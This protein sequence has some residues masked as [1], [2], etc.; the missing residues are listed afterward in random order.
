MFA[1]LLGGFLLPEN[2]QAQFVDITATAG[3]DGV[4]GTQ[5]LTWGDYDAD[6]DLDLFVA[7]QGLYRNDSGV[8]VDVSGTVLLDPIAANAFGG[9]FADYD[10]D[11]DLDL[12]IGSNSPSN[13]FRN[14]GDNTMS[15]VAAS[16]GVN[17]TQAEA[18]S[19]GDYDNDGD[20]DLY[21]GRTTGDNVLY[22]N[23][24]DG[25]FT[26]VTAGA[27]VASSGTQ[28]RAS[29]WGDYDGDGDLDLFV[30]NSINGTPREDA[31]YRNNGDGTFTEVAGDLGMD[32]AG[33]GVGAAWGDYNND[34]HLDLYLSARG[35]QTLYRNNGD[36]TFSNVT[37]T[38]GTV[39]RSAFPQWIDYD[40][41]G[42]L[43]LSLARG[44]AHILYRNN[45]DET[46]TNVAG[47]LGIDDAGESIGALW[48]DVDNDGDLDLYI[49]NGGNGNS[50]LFRNDEVNSNNWLKI[51][52]L[53]RRS[54]R[55]AIG[56]RIEL[57]TDGQSQFRTINGGQNSQPALPVFFGLGGA[58]T[59]DEVRVNW[60]SGA[61]QSVT[62][63]SINQQL[64]IAEPLDATLH[65]DDA[66][67]R[68]GGSVVAGVRITADGPFA[69]VQFT[70]Q[71]QDDG[72]PTDFVR[73]DG[74]IN[75]LETLGFTASIG[76][77]DSDG[78]ATILVFSLSGA[79]IDL[80]DSRLILNLA[81]DIDDTTPPGKRI[82]VVV[83]DVT[84]SDPDNQPGDTAV[85]P[86]AL[87]MGSRGDTAGGDSGDGDGIVSI[88]DLVKLIKYIIGVLPDP[89]GFHLF[90]ADV[91]GDQVLNVQD[92]VGIVNLIVSP[93]QVK[94]S[95][96]GPSRPVVV[97]LGEIQDRS[98]QTVIPIEMKT[99]D[100]VAAIQMMLTF[101]PGTMQLGVPSKTGYSDG[102]IIEHHI[103][104]G[105]MRLV[106]YSADGK[107]IQ[108]G[109]G[110]LFYIPVTWLEK[111]VSESFLSISEIVA[112]DVRAQAFTVSI[113]SDIV[114]M[115]SAP[116]SFS[117]GRNHP[118]P[119]NPATTILYDVPHQ[120][121][122]TLSVYNLLGQEVIR[123]V[124]AVVSPGRHEVVW[125]GVNGR[126]QS[127]ASGIY[128]YRLSTDDGFNDTRRMLLLK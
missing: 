1:F 3:L 15:D 87:V 85:Q 101:S 125:H 60:P 18:V 76:P 102:M 64:V 115:T 54:N 104:G 84:V 59:V 112:A 88:L 29:A 98:G 25:S 90:T 58:S 117:L 97:G 83:T 118:N 105:V 35:G 57:I 6:G 71:P 48:A 32:N 75:E 2:G 53:G 119:F 93:P 73:L 127:V 70:V 28:T 12:Y 96:A 11:G 31:L 56:T 63:V 121:Q 67:S 109:A 23:N 44:G 8:F 78:K 22:R 51:Q 7:R 62:N 13:L 38:A 46:F 14:N 27:G 33:D 89:V 41:D 120:A 17:T 50:R 91:N 122:V 79:R 19:W 39:E 116:A 72:N 128:L 26:D 74:I 92:V 86:G 43:D 21:V 100:E 16:A 82:D 30:V 114:K 9:A 106:A 111:G 5:G 77:V 40:R 80:P 45:G 126:G 107:G 65:I 69:G 81:F 49:S 37:V 113:D 66:F 94:V 124:D 123:L 103:S 108:A 24:G 10:N 68:P 52:A 47:D 99:D 34:G 61:T 20:V 55:S 42:D 95:A 4:T 110:T 36:G